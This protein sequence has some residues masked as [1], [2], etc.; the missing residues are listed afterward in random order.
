[1]PH[2]VSAKK[3]VRQNEK[4]RLHNKERKTRL[5]T[6]AKKLL[7]TLEGGQVDTAQTQLQ[8]LSKLYDKA[9]KT[10]LVHPNKA[11]RVKSKM[12][13]RINRARATA[14]SGT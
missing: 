1:M 11:S 9:A 8:L 6:E 5:K 14:P 10:R 4:R 12:A 3:R 13:R 7:T 2:S